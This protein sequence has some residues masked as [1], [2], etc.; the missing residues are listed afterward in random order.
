MSVKMLIEN[1]RRM[2][3]NENDEHLNTVPNYN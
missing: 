2:R 1:E 3:E